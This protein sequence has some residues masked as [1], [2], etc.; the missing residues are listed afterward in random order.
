SKRLWP[1]GAFRL[2]GSFDL[3]YRI[4]DIGPRS[5][6]DLESD[7]RLPVDTGHAGS[8]FKAPPK[9]GN[10]ANLYDGVTTDFNRHIQNVVGIF[11]KPRYLK[12]EA[13]IAGIHLPRGD[14]PVAA[15][16]KSGNIGSA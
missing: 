15:R 1:I 6:R 10:V 7:R 16:D 3:L 4:D 5:F 8:V 2:D 9:G 13:A 12:G 11:K 14:K